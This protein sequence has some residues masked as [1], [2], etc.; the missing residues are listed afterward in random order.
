MCRIA[1]CYI[2]RHGAMLCILDGVAPACFSP[3]YV[4]MW[5]DNIKLWLLAICSI[6]LG[7]VIHM[8][9]RHGDIP[10]RSLSWCTVLHYAIPYFSM[11]YNMPCNMPCHITTYCSMCP[12]YVISY[13]VALKCDIPG[14]N[15]PR[16]LG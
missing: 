7:Y 8:C 6:V 5:D 11:L 10:F 15:I 12:D 4:A 13:L 9:I 16:F 3:Y 1:L 14:H 2:S